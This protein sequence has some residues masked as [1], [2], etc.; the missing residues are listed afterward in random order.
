MDDSASEGTFNGNSVGKEVDSGKGHLIGVREYHS[1]AIY[2][3]SRVE[4]KKLRT[5]L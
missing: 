3:V 4:E 5:L 1:H 2:R